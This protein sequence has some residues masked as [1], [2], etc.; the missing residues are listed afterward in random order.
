MHG[1]GSNSGPLKTGRYSLKHRASLEAKAQ[2]FLNDASPGDLTGE[3]ALMRAL[4]QDFLERFP[5]GDPLSFDN[6]ERVF[7]MLENIGRNVERISRILN[8]TALTQA[9]VQL[10][11]ARLVEL[12]LNYVDDNRR[13]QFFAEL[14][15][16]FAGNSGGGSIAP[17]Q[18]A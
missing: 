15:A 6:I 2:R 5:E 3:L 18:L 8:A 16:A 1:G 11:Q 4:L 14:G 13:E 7:G 10:L 9:E 17:G 12:A